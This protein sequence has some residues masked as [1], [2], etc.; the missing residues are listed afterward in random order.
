MSRLKKAGRATMSAAD[1]IGT[2]PEWGSDAPAPLPDSFMGAA[3]QHILGQSLM[4]AA[5]QQIREF[6]TTSKYLENAMPTPERRASFIDWLMIEFP[7]QDDAEYCFAS[8]TVAKEELG[9]TLPVVLYIAAFARGEKSSVKC[10]PPMAAN[11]PKQKFPIPRRDE[12]RF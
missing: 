6:K 9:T 4:A 12:P 1:S 11:P 8:P 2:I 7:L 3:T 5:A 10:D